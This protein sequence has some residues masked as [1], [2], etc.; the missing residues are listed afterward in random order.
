VTVPPSTTTGPLSNDTPPDPTGKRVLVGSPYRSVGIV[1][2]QGQY[3]IPTI[4]QDMCGTSG[5]SSCMILM[6]PGT[7]SR[8]HVHRDTETIVVCIE[9]FAATLIGTELEPVFH[10]PGEFIYI[11][12]GVVHVAVNLSTTERAVGME[13]RTDPHLNAD[14]VCTPEHEARAAEIAARLR[15]RYADGDLETPPHWKPHE[16]GPFALESD[17]LLKA[18]RG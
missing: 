14:T 7:A 15:S 8:A 4:T 17:R 12:E 5:L 16:R 1:G 3:L 13:V 11:P 6:P 18:H 9:G 10:G 2:P